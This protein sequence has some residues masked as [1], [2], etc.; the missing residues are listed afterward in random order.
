MATI[1]KLLPVFIL[2]GFMYLN[3][4]DHEVGPCTRPRRLYHSGWGTSWLYPY[5]GMSP[6]TWEINP[7]P[8]YRNF[9]GG[10]P[11]ASLLRR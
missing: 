11:E 10:L 1:I 5:W 7:N 2:T 8:G 9:Y 6:Y 3:T 4:C